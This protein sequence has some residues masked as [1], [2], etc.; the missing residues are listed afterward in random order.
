MVIHYL[1]SMFLPKK[2]FE[3]S[4]NI[5]NVFKNN[6]IKRND[7]INLLKNYNFIFI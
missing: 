7:L 2:V 5:K 4:I 3:N 6:K 1:N